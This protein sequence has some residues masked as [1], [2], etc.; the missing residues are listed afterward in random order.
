MT[1]A[2]GDAVSNASFDWSAT[3]ADY[4]SPAYLRNHFRQAFGK[5]DKG[6]YWLRAPAGMGKTQFIRGVTGKRPAKDPTKTE[7]IDS[8]ISADARSIAFH[9]PKGE[10]IGPRQFVDGLKSAFDSEFA[11]DAEERAQTGAA[12]RYDNPAAAREDFVAW[13]ARL[14]DCAAAKGAKRLLV[15]I[16]GLDLLTEPEPGA[17]AENF[18]LLELLP[19][20]PE[21]PAGV[22]LLISSRPAADWPPGLF[23]RAQARIGVGEGLTAL[24]LS[25]QEKAYIELLQRYFTERLRP[26]FR[27]RA[28][29]H[30]RE[31]LEN[32]TPFE[33]GG[34]DARLTNDPTLRD[35]LKDDWKKLTNKFPRWTGEQLPITPIVEILDQRDKLWIDMIDRTESRF[36]YIAALTARL[37]DGSFAVEQVEGLPK[38]E[39]MLAS[40]GSAPQ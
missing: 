35:G 32:K 18:S 16:D 17:S 21:L 20:A 27:S 10:A 39:A 12:L 14:R 40:L 33:K 4:M 29:A 26:L 8:S 13:L 36:S 30:L 24:D 3:D 1:T 9:I 25:L 5:F 11:L 19:S 7:G 38:G 34:R 23:E 37:L 2:S 31:L 28:Q 15:C 6:I 22:T